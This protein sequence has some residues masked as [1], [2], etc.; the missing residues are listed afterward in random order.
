MADCVFCKIAAGDI[1]SDTVYHDD[2]VVA[3]MDIN[4]VAEGHVLVIPR[5]HS[6]DVAGMR[7]DE[8]ESLALALKK[9]APAAV[10][11]AGS[12]GYNILNNRGHAAGQAVE[13]VHF[14]IIP[15]KTGD[16]RGY[17]WI[18]GEYDKEAGRRLAREISAKIG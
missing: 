7:D 10:V 13:H 1:P 9:I 12:E 6:A 8:L 15:R 4:P 18:T 2:L 17:R 5:R 11:A 3:F 14:H 16:G